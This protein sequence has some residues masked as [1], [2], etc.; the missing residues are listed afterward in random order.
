V[1]LED[2]VGTLNSELKQACD[3][4][5]EKDHYIEVCVVQFL[6][7]LHKLNVF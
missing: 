4:I 3:V 7:E 1:R 5:A 2:D 6:A